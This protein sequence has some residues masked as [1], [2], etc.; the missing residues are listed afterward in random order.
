MSKQTKIRSADTA[1][2]ADLV[3]ALVDA[4]ISCIPILQLA[5]QYKLHTLAMKYGLSALMHSQY[6]RNAKGI[7]NGVERHGRMQHC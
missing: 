3:E 2:L 1:V 4:V 6:C 5:L 7:R